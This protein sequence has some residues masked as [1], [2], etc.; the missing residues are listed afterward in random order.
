MKEGHGMTFISANRRHDMEQRICFSCASDIGRKRKVNQ[1]NF[2]CNGR[3]MSLHSKND[4]V[5]FSG[6]TEPS[7]FQLFGVFDGMGG[8]EYGEVASFLAA[9]DAVDLKQSEYTEKELRALCF[10]SNQKICQYAEDHGLYSMGTTAA[11]LA[12]SEDRIVLCNIGDSKIFRFDGANLNQISI[13]HLTYAPA[14]NKQNL[15]QNLGIPEDCMIIDPYAKTLEPNRDEL[16]ILCSDG[17][18]DMVDAEE[19]GMIASETK[20]SDL[21]DALVKRALEKGGKDNV[22]VVAVKKEVGIS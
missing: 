9:K 13:D 21:A 14:G 1:D 7:G 4:R 16:F 11:L 5:S 22:T 12:F 19:I 2:A 17:L 18:T 20:V 10:R 15:S 8:E 6:Q 3:Y